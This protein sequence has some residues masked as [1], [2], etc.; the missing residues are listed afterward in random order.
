MDDANKNIDE[1]W[2]EAIEKEKENLKEKGGFIPPEADFGFFITTFSLQASIA[3]GQIPN[4]VTDKKEE[5]LSQAKFLIDT[6]AMLKDK[7]KGNLTADESNLLENMLYELRTIYIN[8][9]NPVT[10]TKA[11]LENK[12]DL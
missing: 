5:D 4:P 9:V 7:T 12:Q 10:N 3:L 8:K 6:L 2:K 11:K 1:S